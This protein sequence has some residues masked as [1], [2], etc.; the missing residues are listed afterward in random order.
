MAKKQRQKLAFYDQQVK[1]SSFHDIDRKVK[2]RS[3]S[4]KCNIILLTETTA[5]ERNEKKKKWYPFA[6]ETEIDRTLWILCTLLTK[7]LAFSC[8]NV[9]ISMFF[10]T[11]STPI[12]SIN[13]THYCHFIKV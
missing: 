10:S 4:D 13:S 6:P 9:F 1:K 8:T 3:Q 12:S 7:L 11:P 2:A 5:N